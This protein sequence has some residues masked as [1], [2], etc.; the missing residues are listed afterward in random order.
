MS[1]KHRPGNDRDDPGKSKP[2]S[3]PAKESGTVSNSSTTPCSEAIAGSAEKKNELSER[4]RSKPTAEWTM[5]WLTF[6]LAFFA[7][8][9]AWI[10]Y[11]QLDEMHQT[12]I[13]SQRPWVNAEKFDAHR[14]TLPPV[15]RFTIYGDVTMRNSGVSIARDGWV[16]M[17]AK[18]NGYSDLKKEWDDACKTVSTSI[19]AGNAW[20]IGFVLDPNQSTQLPHSI[21]ADFTAQQLRNGFYLLGCAKYIDQFG[22]LHTTRFCFRPDREVY[23]ADGSVNPLEFQVCNG[24]QSAD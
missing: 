8:L 15:G 22:I 20:P 13:Q 21:Q 18:A 23:G 9:S 6:V 17:V 1:H 5:V 2:E 12:L 14:M 16:A 7:A 3:P 4:W 24:F 19:K 11:R 10:F